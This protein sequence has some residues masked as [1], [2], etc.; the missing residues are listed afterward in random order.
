MFFSFSFII[1]TN[2]HPGELNEELATEKLL[3][4]NRNQLTI[5]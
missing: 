4:W 2:G 1:I 5:A 3:E